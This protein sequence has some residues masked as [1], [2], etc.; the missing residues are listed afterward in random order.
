VASLGVVLPASRK[1][2]LIDAT[3]DVRA[4]LHR[5][6][7]L[8]DFPPG[9][10]DRDPLSGIFLTHA[11]MGHYLGLAHFGFEA[12]H[13][14][15]LPTYV[16]PRMAAFLQENGPWSQLVTKGNLAIEEIDPGPGGTFGVPVELGEGVRVAALQVPHRDEYSDTV[17]FLIEGPQTRYLY[18]PDTDTWDTWPRELTEVLAEVDVAL[19]DGTFYSLDELPGRDISQVRHPLVTGTVDLLAPAVESGRLAVY[20]THFNHTNPLVEPEGPARR[21]VEERGFGVLDDGLMLPL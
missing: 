14:Q 8:Q 9:R 2:F 20:F 13:T 1:V 11:H 4:Q 7:P 5:L 19:L 16:T 18:V 17:A 15:G 10:V 6:L 21:Q 3:P 12:V